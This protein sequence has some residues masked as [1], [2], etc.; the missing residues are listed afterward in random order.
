MEELIT[1]RTDL[2]YDES[3]VRSGFLDSMS[4]MKLLLF[5]EEQCG[6]KIADQ[7]LVPQNFESIR[8]IEG[9]LEKY[10][11]AAPVVAAQ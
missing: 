11:S 2:D 10:A 7:D 6:A 9:I 5:L 8:T 1:G 4:I 3:L